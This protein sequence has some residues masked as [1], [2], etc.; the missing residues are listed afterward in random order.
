MHV[1]GLPR[2]SALSRTMRGES[3][4]WDEGVEL[5]AQTLDAIKEQSYY[6]LKVNGN[7][8]AP[9]VPTWRP[10]APGA[11]VETGS[12]ADFNALIGG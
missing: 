9:P 12:L 5:S 2:D 11:V 6:L 8:P 10:G 7:D 3:A 4:Y 1:K